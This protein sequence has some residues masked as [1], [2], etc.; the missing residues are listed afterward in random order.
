[1]RIVAY[2]VGANLPVRNLRVGN[3]P[4]R[5]LGGDVSHIEIVV[6]WA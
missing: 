5:R 6:K 4:G 2:F 3:L 1:M